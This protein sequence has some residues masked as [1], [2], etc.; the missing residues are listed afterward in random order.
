VKDLL[1]W[2]TVVGTA[3]LAAVV[4]IAVITA[5]KERKPGERKQ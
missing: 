3:I 2:R 5:M 1:F 4:L